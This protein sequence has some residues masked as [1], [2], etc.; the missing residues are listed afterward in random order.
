TPELR[1]VGSRH[2]TD[3]F[4]DDHRLTQG[5]RESGS[6]SAVPEASVDER[7]DPVAGEHDVWAYPS[8]GQIDAVV[9]TVAEP[10]SMKSG[11]QRALGLRVPTTVRLHVPTTSG[12]RRRGDAQRAVVCDGLHDTKARLPS[13]SGG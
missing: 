11:P 1:R 9:H 3:S 10:C 4:R 2:S 6:G 8:A 13:S 7:R 12:A 5:V